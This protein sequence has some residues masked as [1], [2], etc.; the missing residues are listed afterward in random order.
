MGREKR[1]DEEDVMQSSIGSRPEAPAR[2]IPF[3]IAVA[4]AGALTLGALLGSALIGFLIAGS[5]F[6]GSRAH[7]PRLH[8]P[9]ARHAAYQPGA[10]GIVIGDP[11]EL[12][13]LATVDA[14]TARVRVLRTEVRVR[15]R[16]ADDVRRI[17]ERVISEEFPRGDI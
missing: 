3:A 14:A 8:H 7:C 2:G 11:C 1:E 4:G 16:V 12:Q 6:A 13:A 10:V 17:V 5:A 15:Q 9:T